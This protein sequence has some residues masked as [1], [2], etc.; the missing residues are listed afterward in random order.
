MNWGIW[1]PYGDWRHLGP[2]AIPSLMPRASGAG[3]GVGEAS[4]GGSEEKA[5]SAGTPVPGTVS[6]SGL[7]SPRVI[8]GNGFSQVL[9][10]SSCVHVEP[11]N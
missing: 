2:D 7:P 4:R 5:A 6:A 11:G 9:I 3:I 10:L 1:A 8:Q